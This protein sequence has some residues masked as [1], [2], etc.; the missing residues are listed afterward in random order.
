MAATP[1]TKTILA[2]T[3]GHPGQLEALEKNYR[4]IRLWQERDPES[5]IKTHAN[6]IVAVTASVNSPVRENLISALPNLEIIAT[7]TVGFD[8]IDLEAAKARNIVVTNTPDVLTDEVSNMAI[9]LLLA[10]T[11][12]VV[13]GDAFVRAGL[14]RRQG[15]PLG[16]SL[17]GKTMGIVGMG[18]IGQAI[19]RKGTAFGLQS[20]YYGPNKKDLPYTYVPDLADLAI[21]SDFLVLACPGGEA[22]R[23][24]VDYNILGHLGAK[25]YLVNIARGSVVKEDDLL[26]ALSNKIIAG[27][28]LDVYENEPGVPESLF[29]MDNV[30]LTPHIGSATYET[31]K[32][33]G[34]LVVENIEACLHGRAV[35]TPVLK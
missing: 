24:I 26:V 31:R 3:H 17:Q 10:V 20:I 15:F 14:W 16:V 27:A 2:L 11:R 6:N 32:E 25:G 18:A 29:V 21:Q 5:A 7:G 8:H 12:R 4:I 33:M 35:L 22:T 34:T 13:E 9:A 19:A 30:V 1:A 23:H 28:A